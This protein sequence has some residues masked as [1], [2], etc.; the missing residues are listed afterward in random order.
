MKIPSSDIPQADILE[1]VVAVVKAVGEGKQSFQDI[2][3]YL[4]KVERQGRYY[5]K[6]AELLGF[7][8]NTDNNSVLTPLGKQ[9]LA[10]SEQEK[11]NLLLNAVFNTRLFQRM[12]PFLEADSEGVTRQEIQNFMTEVTDQ[13]GK[14]MMPRRVSTF[15]G[16]LEYLSVL[17]KG[18][19]NRY[20]LSATLSQH[21]SLL[22]FNDGEPL[23]P[24]I[25]S[26]KEYEIVEERT[27]KAIAQTPILRNQIASERSAKAHIRLVN[28][29]AKRLRDIGMLPR[30]NHLVDLAAQFREHSYIFEMKSIT[31]DNARSQIRS[32]LSQ[33][34]EYR[35]LQNIPDAILVLVVE[36]PLPND[37]QWMSEYLEKDRRVR[38]L[39]DGNNELFASQ[40][41]IR[42]MQFL[43][44]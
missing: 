40:E 33:L 37:I 30:C 42:E 10:S 14:S 44:G 24:K 15:I 25:K 39:W 2:A 3:Q 9:F 7:I 18:S 6:A 20:K 4:G 28:M 31:Q 43:W 26:L 1:D 34:Y 13:V 5:R 35:Y 17:T 21:I 23:L 27:S 32:G 22:E 12:I 11:K 41:T 29:V 19:H 16:W 38:L 36:I 8:R